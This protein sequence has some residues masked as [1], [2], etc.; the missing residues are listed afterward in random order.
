MLRILA[1]SITGWVSVFA[2][3]LETALPYLIRSGVLR[4]SEIASTERAV[5]VANLRVRLRTHYWIG[6]S[7]GLLVLVHACIVMGPAMARSDSLGIWSATG[8]LCLLF[9]QVVVGLSLREVNTHSKAR[10]LRFHFWNMILL[11]VLVSI[12]ILRNAN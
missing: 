12:H 6:Y 9:A 10:A 8:A 1:V 3:G 4:S 7:L 5:S 2:I 11:V